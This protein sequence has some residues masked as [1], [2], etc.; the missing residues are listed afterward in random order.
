MGTPIETIWDIEPHTEAKH[1][2]LKAYLSAWYPIL[3][4]NNNRLNYI[5]GFSGPGKY[6]KGEPGSPL[7]VLNLTL[8]HPSLNGV[9]LNFIFIE[10][11][12]KRKENLEREIAQLNLPGNFRFEVLGGQFHDVIGGILDK[13]ESTDQI[14]APTF[15]FIDPFGF[16]GIPFS[17]I[18]RLLRMP[19]VEVFIT[20]MV[21]RINQ[22]INDKKNNQ[23]IIELFG[24]EKVLEILEKNPDNRYDV[25]RTFY[26]KQLCEVAGAKFVRFFTMKNINDRP[27]YDLFFATKHRLGH[28]KM[29][30]AMWSIDDEGLFRFSDG[31][32]QNQIVLFKPDS[33]KELFEIINKKRTQSQYQV[34][35]IKRFVED[36]SAFLEKHMK[37]SLEYAEENGF[38][39]VEPLKSDGKKR[40]GKTFPDEVIINFKNN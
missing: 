11:D 35:R 21:D 2:I 25:L 40:H 8:N 33:R 1:K 23:H 9:E 39:N 36:E 22:F 30:E 37:K 27:I 34:K 19:K 6:S 31:T 13:L 17:I 32:D 10:K 3:K 5:D 14:L 26:Q 20:F 12:S 29:K 24:S 4:S 18:E 28:I 16:S 38:I 7:V 15:V